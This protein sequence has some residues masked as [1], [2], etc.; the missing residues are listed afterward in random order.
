MEPFP[1]TCCRRTQTDSHPARSTARP[2]SSREVSALRGRCPLATRAVPAPFP[3]SNTVLPTDAIVSP[4]RPIT[5]FT[6]SVS[7]VAHAWRT[8]GGPLNTMMLPVFRSDGEKKS[9]S[10]R[11]RSPSWRV[12]YI[13]ADGTKKAWK[14]NA[15]IPTATRAATTAIVAHFEHCASKGPLPGWRRWR[16]VARVMWAVDCYCAGLLVSLGAA[17]IDSIRR[18]TRSSW[19]R[20]GSFNSTVRCV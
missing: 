4:G 15:R 5:R 8:A 17:H 11:I 12:G 20:N 2:G 7:A 14:A 19:E 3:F 1:T 18:S 16:R 6:R 13:D 9:L 10:T